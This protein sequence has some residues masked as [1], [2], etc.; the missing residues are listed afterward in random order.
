M[1]HV[2]ASPETW[3]PG[4]LPSEY[5]IVHKTHYIKLWTQFSIKYKYR[6]FFASV[7]PILLSPKPKLS[8][9]K[10]NSWILYMKVTIFVLALK[11][12]YVPR[13]DDSIVTRNRTGKIISWIVGVKPEG[14]FAWEI[15]NFK[16]LQLLWEEADLVFV[17]C[18][19]L[20]TDS[21]TTNLNNT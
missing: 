4:I 18:I 21:I 17:I 15:D 7:D 14:T 2:E 16:C 8:N 10:L 1:G 19:D 20:S 3:L 12:L 9:T 5:A 6:K 13:S 11:S